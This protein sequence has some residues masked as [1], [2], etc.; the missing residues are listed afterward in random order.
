MIR[1]KPDFSTLGKNKNLL[2]QE[3][4]AADNVVQISLH[5]LIRKI[6]GREAGSR[7]EG[8]MK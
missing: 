1:N 6:G 3:S 2:M 8:E 7:K 4:D 5:L